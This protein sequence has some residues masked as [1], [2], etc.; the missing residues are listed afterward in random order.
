[1]DE[2]LFVV[3]GDDRFI[4]TDRARGPWS[5]D[6]LHGG[7]VAAL[8]VQQAEAALAAT[9]APAHLP[10]RLTI[11]LERPVPLAP[12][13]VHTEIVRPGGKV[14]VA[15]VEVRDA[16]DRRLVRAGVLAIRR[17][18]I[19]LPDD[20]ITPDDAVLPGPETG[21]SEEPWMV[22]GPD[23]EAF[24][25]HGVE[26]RYTAGGFLR[27]GPATDWIR[28]AQPVLAGVEPSGFQR[29]AAAADFVNGVAAVLGFDRWRFINPDLTVTI[30]RQPVGAWIGVD[31][32]SRLDRDG[33]GTAE[34]DL[35]D[36]HG[37]FGRSVQTLLVEPV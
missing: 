28:L 15:Q 11:D 25:S 19:P 30:H 35:H 20:L 2:A 16:D 10:V 4:P 12:L 26:H 5:I 23:V 22:Y 21:R 32:V 7:P 3:D 18:P 33:I 14:Q 9:G 8:V 17:R 37:R 24:H 27:I 1:M 36:E 13:R 6:A 34:A 31:A 29:A